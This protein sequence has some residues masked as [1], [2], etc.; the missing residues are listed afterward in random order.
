MDKIPQNKT[1][2]LIKE[3]RARI[4]Q[5]HITGYGAY[6]KPRFSA[7]EIVHLVNELDKLKKLSK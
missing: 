1:D 5:A 4:K 3:V 2:S 6:I 7:S